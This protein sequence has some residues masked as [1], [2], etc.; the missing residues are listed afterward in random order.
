[1]HKRLS[2]KVCI[3]PPVLVDA[4]SFV[5]SNWRTE[6]QNLEDDC[7]VEPI[8]ERERERGTREFLPKNQTA[9]MF[10]LLLGLMVIIHPIPRLNSNP[11]RVSFGWQLV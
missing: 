10:L 9:G 8:I 1:M 5:Y 4:G 11:A 6:S 2:V 3:C 7:P